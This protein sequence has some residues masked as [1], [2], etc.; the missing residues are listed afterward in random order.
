MIV[1][2]EEFDISALRQK[3]PEAFKELIRRFHPLLLSLV[4]PMVGDGAAEEIAQEAWIKVY[5]AIDRFEGRSQLKTWVS[6]IALNEARMHLRKHKQEN[7]LTESMGE[8]GALDG[9]FRNDGSWRAAP[10]EWRSASVD[11]LLMRD[12]LIECIEKTM[13][14]LPV[15]QSALLRLRDI[16]GLTFDAICN[17]LDITASNARVLLHRARGE[18]YQMLEHYEETGEC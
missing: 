16:E 6:A 17:E 7:S 1:D 15:N 4:R 3:N 5:D 18:L 11:D 10:M 9:K 8:E 13:N 14:Q 2:N 12:N